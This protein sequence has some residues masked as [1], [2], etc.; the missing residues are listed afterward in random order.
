MIR[1]MPYL[2]YH[3]IETAGGEMKDASPGF[4]RY[5]VMESEFKAQLSSLRNHRFKGL[6][7]GEALGA[8]YRDPGIV[9]TF[10][11]GSESD[12]TVAAPQLKDAGFNATFYIVV[13][14]VGRSGFLSTSQLRELAGTGFEIGCHSM[15]HP[16]LNDLNSRELH[17]QI[18]EAKQRLE[19]MIG[20][21]VHHF[22]CPGGRWSSQV[23]AIA[24]A[25]GYHSVVTSEAILN[26]PLADPFRLGRVAI[27]RG[28]SL[29]AFGQLCHGKGVF[30]LRSQEMAFSLAKAV[31]GNAMYEKL[32]EAVLGS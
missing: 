19:Q 29:T 24:R 8:R 2:M 25:A 12:L 31:L 5:V 16:Y 30:F 21:P 11:D 26:R 4:S 32:R 15:T 6:S 27:K 22:S 3:E 17:L 23:A 28:L 20:Q 9:L 13:G 14:Y 10:D 7:V 18:V 1:G